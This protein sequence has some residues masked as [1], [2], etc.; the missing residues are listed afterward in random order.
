VKIKLWIGIVGLCLWAGGVT[1]QSDCPSQLLFEAGDIARVTPGAANNL[2]NVPSASGEL[3]GQIPGEGV[4]MVTGEARCDEQFVWLP[5]RY[6][7]INGWTVQGTADEDFVEA[8]LDV[9]GYI[10]EVISLAYPAEF[11][12]TV[13]AEYRA[14]SNTQ[15]GLLPEYMAYEF[16]RTDDAGDTETVMY[17]YLLP[18]EPLTEEMHVPWQSLQSVRAVLG[19]YGDTRDISGPQ[20]EITPPNGP[21]VRQDFPPFPIGQGT[22]RILIAGQHEVPMQ[23]GRGVAFLA[24]GTHLMQV[25]VVRSGLRYQYVG[26]AAH[27]ERYLVGAWFPVETDLLPERVPNEDLIR[28]EEDYE[29]F[30]AYIVETTAQLTDAPPSAFMPDLNTLDSIINSLYVVPGWEAEKGLG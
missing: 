20:I 4:F 30:R 2:R 1:A 22:V 11:A 18:I 24:Y 17:L 26:L 7:G 23:A 15:S 19:G 27:N 10:D 21:A 13:E 6:E 16:Q 9:E 28:Y 3:F 25:P 14:S 29:A 8:V 5:V 12:D